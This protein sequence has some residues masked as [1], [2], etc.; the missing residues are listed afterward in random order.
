MSCNEETSP[1]IRIL[2]N[3][4]DELLFIQQQAVFV[5]FNVYMISICRLYWKS[6]PVSFNHFPLGRS[7]TVLIPVPSST[8]CLLEK[9]I[10]AEQHPFIVPLKEIIIMILF[11]LSGMWVRV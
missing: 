7:N 10:K 3:L 8:G 6:V 9:G 11:L 5:F 2:E 1:A 4:F